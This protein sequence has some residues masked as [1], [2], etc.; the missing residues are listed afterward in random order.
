[1]MRTSDAST[2]AIAIAVAVAIAIVIAC[3]VAA[4]IGVAFLHFFHPLLRL[5]R[6]LLRSQHGPLHLRIVTVAR[7]RLLQGLLRD[8]LN[9]GV[10]A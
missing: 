6:G 2:V 9:V 3:V 1:M 4:A 5:I 7:D 10:P 8:D